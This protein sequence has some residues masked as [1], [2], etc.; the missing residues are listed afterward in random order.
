MIRPSM[1]RAANAIQAATI[2][3]EMGDDELLYW[4]QSRAWWYAERVLIQLDA[5]FPDNSNVV[6]HGIY[7]CTREIERQLRPEE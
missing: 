2:D 7:S 1:I 3:I 4:R 6:A 5:A